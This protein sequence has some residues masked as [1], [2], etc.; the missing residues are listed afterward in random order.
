MWFSIRPHTGIIAIYELTV[1]KKVPFEGDIKISEALARSD[2]NDAADRLVAELVP[3]GVSHLRVADSRIDAARYTV[4]FDVS[5]LVTSGLVDHNWANR[6][7]PVPP[8]EVRVLGKEIR[9][10]PK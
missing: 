2:W 8:P 1:Q 6:A 7:G 4:S 3:P 9:I 10:I 5:D